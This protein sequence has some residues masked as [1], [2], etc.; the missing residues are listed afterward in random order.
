MR[1]H[2]PMDLRLARHEVILCEFAGSTARCYPS[3]T[4]DEYQSEE[5]YHDH[6][7]RH[8]QDHDYNHWHDLC[9]WQLNESEASFSGAHYMCSRYRSYGLC[10]LTEFLCRLCRQSNSN[11]ATKGQ[12][13]WSLRCSYLLNR[14]AVDRVGYSHELLNL[15]NCARS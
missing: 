12:K 13:L 2:Q 5:G 4:E 14:K 7:N 9:H 10:V 8:N 6:H 3:N 11:K 15:V 1:S